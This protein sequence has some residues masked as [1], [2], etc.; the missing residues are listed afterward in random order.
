MEDGRE[1]STIIRIRYGELQFPV[2]R[3]MSWTDH[4]MYRRNDSVST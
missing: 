1:V 3:F 2:V 4:S